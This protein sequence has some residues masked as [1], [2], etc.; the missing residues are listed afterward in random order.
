M[1]LE[2]ISNG[3]YYIIQLNLL[4]A[5][6]MQIYSTISD[7]TP[8]KYGEHIFSRTYILHILL[9]IDMPRNAQLL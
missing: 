5:R 2:S 3:C 9:I 7:Q 6:R 4:N 8:N 1:F